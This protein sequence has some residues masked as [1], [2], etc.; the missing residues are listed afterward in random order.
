MYTPPPFR[1]GVSAAAFN[2]FGQAHNFEI[3]TYLGHEQD[4]ECVAAIAAGEGARGDLLFATACLGGEIRVW[5]QVRASSLP[6]VVS[7]KSCASDVAL[8]NPFAAWAILLTWS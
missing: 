3:A 5:D 8:L 2:A 4:I 6:L 1:F 7:K